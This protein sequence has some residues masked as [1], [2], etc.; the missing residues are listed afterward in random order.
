MLSDDTFAPAA[1]LVAGLKL[2]G[3]DIDKY[4][5]NW[6]QKQFQS[7][8]STDETDK[9]DDLIDARKAARAAKNWAEA[10]RI[11]DELDGMG[12]QLMDAK[13]PDTDELVTTWEVKR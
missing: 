13:D 5:P 2:L 1:Q 7:R 12:I 6:L 9:I 11:R 3:I 8:I 10:D 4:D